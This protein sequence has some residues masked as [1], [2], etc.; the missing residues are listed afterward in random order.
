MGYMRNRRP[1]HSCQTA[2]EVTAST[3][4]SAPVV[5]DEEVGRVLQTFPIIQWAAVS[6]CLSRASNAWQHCIVCS[7]YHL[8][9]RF[10]GCSKILYF[11]SQ[12]GMRLSEASFMDTYKY[13]EKKYTYC[14][15]FQDRFPC[16]VLGALEFTLQTRVVSNSEISL[17]CPL[18]AGIKGVCQPG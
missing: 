15:V 10:Q 16:V 4:P 3:D 2:G 9:K 14:F 8:L 1:H 5:Q 12:E 6:A 17:I 13:L 7:F 11:F 18:N